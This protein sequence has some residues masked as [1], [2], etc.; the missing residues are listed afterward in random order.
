M[1][2][3][4]RWLLVGGAVALLLFLL[5]TGRLS[6]IAAAVAAVISQIYRLLPLLRYVPFLKKLYQRW[7]AR[8]S[9]TAGATGNQTSTVRSRFLSMT[10]QH[11]TGVMEGEVLEGQFK[12][13][14]L[15]QLSLQQLLLFLAE[16]QLDSDSCSLLTTFLD[17]SYPDW[18]DRVS[19]QAYSTKHDN[20]TNTVNQK[21]SE[22]EAYQILGL[23]PGASR[24]QIIQSHRRLMQKLHPD[25]GGTTYLAAK[26]NLAKQVLL[27]S[28]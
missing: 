11:D 12:G 10:L 8:Q 18:R 7:Q 3:I 26:I 6:W 22:A 27:K 19:E 13:K 9:A 1:L 20:D 5:A 24:E 17:R 28:E 21:M 15:S 14:L 4:T 23:E 2:K 25:H 16:C